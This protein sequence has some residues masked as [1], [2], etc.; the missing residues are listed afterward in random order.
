MVYF[1][2]NQKKKRQPFYICEHCAR[3]SRADPLQKGDCVR[4]KVYPGSINCKTALE[5][6]EGSAIKALWQNVQVLG[7]TQRL[8]ANFGLNNEM[9]AVITETMLPNGQVSV[10]PKQQLFVEKE[11]NPPFFF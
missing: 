6:R 8:H 2:N 10:L 7:G 3:A 4:K 1:C 5:R 9:T 11:L